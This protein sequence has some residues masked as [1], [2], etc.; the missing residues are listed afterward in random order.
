MKMAPSGRW[1]RIKHTHTH[2]H[3]HTHRDEK[4]RFSLQTELIHASN[5]VVRSSHRRAGA[6]HSGEK[7]VCEV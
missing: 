2:L 4:V 1:G 6:A 3:K 7:R 5:E